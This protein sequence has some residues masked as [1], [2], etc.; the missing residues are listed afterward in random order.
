[1]DGLG[2]VHLVVFLLMVVMLPLMVGSIWL[3]RRRAVHSAG[4]LLLAALRPR[5]RRWSLVFF[6][7][8]ALNVAAEWL[9]YSTSGPFRVRAS[10]VANSTLMLVSAMAM[11]HIGGV[12]WYLELCEE[13]IV[14]HAFFSGWSQIREFQWV[15]APAVLQIWYRRRGPVHYGIALQQRDA[16]DQLLRAHVGTPRNADRPTAEPY[17]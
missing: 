7:V 17:S 13:G 10:S 8:L 16:V 6:G 15:G 12:G 11:Y 5:Y 1:M 3:A 14:D 9:S 4:G 2:W